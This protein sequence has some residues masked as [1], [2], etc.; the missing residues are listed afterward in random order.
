MKTTIGLLLLGLLFAPRCT[1]GDERLQAGE[2]LK[3]VQR[4]YEKI[5]DASA[6]FEQTVVLKYTNVEQKFSGSIRMKKPDKYR[7]ESDQQSLVTDGKTVWIYSPVNRQV[8]VDEYREDA[9]SFSAE[10]F[11]FGLPTEFTAA[12]LDEKSTIPGV[13]YV[14]K[15]VPKP[16]NASIV[17]WLKVW[18][19]S[20]DWSVRKVE[21]ADQN[22][23][24][25]SYTLHDLAFDRGLSDSLFVFTV[26]QGVET[27]DMRAARQKAKRP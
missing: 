14:L 24:D 21:Y 13:D 16:G 27:I 25:I 15:L 2:V 7:L 20:E 23:T 17:K 18:V 19:R 22:D 12:I 6:S 10:K 11:L 5:A 1:A 4:R 9:E 3:N 8:L 26:P